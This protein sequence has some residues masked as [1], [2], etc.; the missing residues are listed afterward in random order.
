M[1]KRV[2]II[3]CSHS[4]I[5]DVDHINWTTML[6]NKHPDIMFDNYAASGHGHLYMDIVLKHI[7]YQSLI[8]YDLI[9][10]QT[11]GSNRWSI[12]LPA[13]RRTTVP[14][15][16][17]KV[18]ENLVKVIMDS[19]RYNITGAN[20]HTMFDTLKPLGGSLYQDG[21]VIPKHKTHQYEPG[22]QTMA[23]YFSQLFIL[24]L[25]KLSN[26]I[27]IVYFG[28]QGGYCGDN[29]GLEKTLHQIIKEDRSE[30]GLANLLDDT[31]HFTEE[32]YSV[33]LDILESKPEFTKYF[34]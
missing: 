10:V 1:K 22:D 18:S 28:M 32:G 12:P 11:T 9:I 6:A 24:Q 4:D 13:T 8:D 31:L 34:Q 29:I 27:P 3:G 2:A 33:M 14:W 30:E 23:L 25:R 19:P 15:I 7:L 16:R 17:K 26:H 20:S 5:A 21:H